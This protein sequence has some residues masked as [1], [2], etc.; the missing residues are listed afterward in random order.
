MTAERL[1]NFVNVAYIVAGG[2]IAALTIAIYLLSSHVSAEKDRAFAQFK[3]EAQ[4]QIATANAQIARAN[5]SVEAAKG[6]NLRLQVEIEKE[7]LARAKIEERLAP[8]VM[9]EEQSNQLTEALG[10]VPKQA[11][12]ISL[13]SLSREAQNFSGQISSA[14]EKAGFSTH[15]DG[16]LSN[17]DPDPGVSVLVEDI[18]N[19]P[20]AASTIVTVLKHLGFSSH[21]G[22]R[23]RIVPVAYKA[24][25]IGI[26]VG[27]KQ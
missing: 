10:K 20:E 12:E 16:Y 14:A 1:L 4:K 11:I 24:G 8:R 21:I 15:V 26:F 17:A 6:A 9:T 13:Y 3:A 19:I 7:K 2:I 22:Y 23:S 18:K 25:Q 5:V 27:P